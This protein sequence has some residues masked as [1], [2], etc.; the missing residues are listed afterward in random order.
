MVAP[1][2]EIQTGAF[3]P[4]SQSKLR[5]P[6]LGFLP[7]FAATGF[8]RFFIDSRSRG[9]PTFATGFRRLGS[10]VGEISGVRVS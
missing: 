3:A 7:A 4:A 8:H 1:S 9:F 6:L 10:I 2:S 5:S